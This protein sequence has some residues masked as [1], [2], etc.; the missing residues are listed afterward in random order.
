MNDCVRSF[1]QRIQCLSGVYFQHSPKRLPFPNLPTCA[2]G[3]Y[4]RRQ[5]RSLPF[6]T[7]AFIATFSHPHRIRKDMRAFPQHPHPLLLLMTVTVYL[8]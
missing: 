5:L 1:A 6:A 3:I 7:V 2:A 8:W 4:D